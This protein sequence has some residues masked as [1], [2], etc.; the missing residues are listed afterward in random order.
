MNQKPV[1]RQCVSCK[2]VFNRMKLFKVTKDHQDGVV[3]DGGM[4]RSAYICPT[5]TCLDEALRRKR[6]QKALRTPINFN[7]IEVLKDRLNR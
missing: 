1:L 2:K 3:I 5:E 4:G 6:L 7:V